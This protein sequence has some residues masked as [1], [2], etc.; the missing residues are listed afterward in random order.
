VTGYPRDLAGYGA[1]PPD[2]RWPGGARLA[3]QIAVNYEEGSEWGSLLQSAWR[4][5]N[6]CGQRL[7]LAFTCRR[8]SAREP[9][10]QVECA[11]GQALTIQ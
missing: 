11:V 2:P 10:G 9:G 6:D 1:T 4:K 5:R 3:L 8:A 7:T